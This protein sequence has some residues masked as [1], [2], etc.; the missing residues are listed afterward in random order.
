[1][2][3]VVKFERFKVKDVHL[4]FIKTNTFFARLMLKRDCSH[5]YILFRFQ[6]GSITIINPA[7]YRA[8]VWQFLVKDDKNNLY[9]DFDIKGFYEAKHRRIGT[10]KVFGC[11]KVEPKSNFK[12]VTFMSFGSLSCVTVI[13]YA[14]GMNKPFIFTP[15]QLYRYLKKRENK[16]WA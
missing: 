16:L 7:K 12:K 2:T 6:D 11:L 5:V 9:K 4:V 13:K 10:F 1:M 3:K 15:Y 14:L 8:H